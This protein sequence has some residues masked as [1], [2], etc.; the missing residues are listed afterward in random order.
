VLPGLD[1][2]AA[3]PGSVPTSAA[4]EERIVW[5]GSLSMAVSAD[6][7]VDAGWRPGCGPPSPCLMFAPAVGMMVCIPVPYAGPAPFVARFRL[8]VSPA[9]VIIDP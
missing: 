7:A 5:P 2:R 1:V 8:T 6:I 9:A 3:S 4:R